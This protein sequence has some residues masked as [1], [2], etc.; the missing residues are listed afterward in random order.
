MTDRALS[1]EAMLASLQD[2]SLPAHAAG[3]LIA[4]VAVTV[5]L[6]GVAAFIVAGG[7]RLFSQRSRKSH[8]P[9]L[10]DHLARAQAF[11]E[12]RRRVLLLHLLRQHAPERYAQ[13]A[14]DLYRRETGIT[15][16]ALQAEL[17]RLV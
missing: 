1:E 9:S 2:I 13:L 4:D 7:L 15:A 12:T 3:G 5:G 16:E 10:R 11:P 8:P 14:R 17:E 6:A